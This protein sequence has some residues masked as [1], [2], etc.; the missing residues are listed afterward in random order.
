MLSMAGYFTAIVRAPITGV[1]LITEMTGS[2]SNL[3]SLTL[4]SIVAYIVADLLN[5][6]PIYESLMDR[7][8]RKNNKE[9]YHKESSKKIIVSNVVHFGS[10][11]ENKTVRDSKLGENILLVSIKRGEEDIIPRGST[12]IKAGDQLFAVTDLKKEWRTREFL[13]EITTSST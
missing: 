4:V 13:E 1:I 10:E 12:V 5:S 7:L 9:N 3:L 8:L 2:F 11:I 6:E